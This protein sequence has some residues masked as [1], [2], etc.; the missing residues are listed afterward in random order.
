MVQYRFIQLARQGNSKAIATLLNSKLHPEGINAKASVVN[1][2]LH[3]LLE[4]DELPDRYSTINVVRNQLIELA[5]DS[6]KRVKLLFKRYIDEYPTWGQEFDL[7]LSYLSDLNLTSFSARKQNRFYP[8]SK[9][10]SIKNPGLNNLR[11]SETTLGIV[12]II[13]FMAL[14]VFIGKM[15]LNQ[16]SQTPQQ[17]KLRIQN[18]ELRIQNSEF[19]KRLIRSIWHS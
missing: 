2:W 1:S 3:I 13:L 5:P 12:G 6:I 19:Q 8:N 17:E 7:E 16:S 9:I 15:L 14:V 11:M 4:S 18:L 10:N